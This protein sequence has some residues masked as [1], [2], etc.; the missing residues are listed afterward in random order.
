[1]PALAA[2]ESVSLKGTFSGV[3]AKF[4][5]YLTLLGDFE[6][7]IDNSVEPPTTTWTAADNY[8]VTNQTTSFVIDF[9]DPSRPMFTHT[10][11]FWLLPAGAAVLATPPLKP[12]SICARPAPASL[13][14]HR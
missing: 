10:P 12:C 14:S 9:S 13:T 5:S 11:R 8:T 1:M 3:G 2:A 6:G 4:S 7:V